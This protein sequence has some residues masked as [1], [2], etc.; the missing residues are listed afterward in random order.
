MLSKL[1]VEGTVQ[2]VCLPHFQD[3]TTL[4]ILNSLQGQSCP[5]VPQH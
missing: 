1:L 2:G 5:F 3:L 4:C